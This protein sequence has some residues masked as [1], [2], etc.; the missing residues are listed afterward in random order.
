MKRPMLNTRRAIMSLLLLLSA[1]VVGLPASVLAQYTPP[2]RGL[3][4]RREGG[5]TR[6]SATTTCVVGDRSLLA[7]IPETVF[8]TTVKAA[9]TL[10]WYV[11]E[12]N[13]AGLEFLLYDEEGN[14][15]FSQ[16]IPPAD[17]AGIVGITVPLLGEG[18]GSDS[19]LAL[20][21][22]YH[23][24]FSIIC[25]EGDRSADV[26]AEGWVQRIPLSADLDAQLKTTPATEQAEVYASAGIWYDA[27]DAS[28]QVR[29]EAPDDAILR[30]QWANLL[31]TV[32]LEAVAEAPLTAACMAD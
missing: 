8:G 19:R 12:V 17:E 15:V 18:E 28:T 16:V 24:F 4:G 10:Y 13:A 20:N 25:D 22:N 5:G 27:L 23:W 14:E 21:E 30:T 26:F 7:L 29:C 31:S 11:P 2:D 3:P 6:G 32:G 9:P 1:A